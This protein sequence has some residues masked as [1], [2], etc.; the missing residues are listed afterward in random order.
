MLTTDRLAFV[1]AHFRVAHHLVASTFAMT[2][3]LMLASFLVACLL[4]DAARLV[5]ALC[6]LACIL[7]A[8]LLGHKE[9]TGALIVYALVAEWFYLL[10]KVILSAAAPLAGCIVLGALLIFARHHPSTVIAKVLD[11]YQPAMDLAAIL[12]NTTCWVSMLGIA[13]SK[14]PYSSCLPLGRGS[15]SYPNA[16]LLWTARLFR[17]TTELLR[18]GTDASSFAMAG[19]EVKRRVPMNLKPTTRAYP[20]SGFWPFVNVTAPRM[21]FAFQVLHTDWEFYSRPADI[22]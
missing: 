3:Y 22:K 1:Y 8:F 17:S 5:S 12:T 13:W 20:R 11:N 19:R 6:I 21:P 2:D 16:P 18:S 10:P 4:I 9:E 14:T 7:S 15:G